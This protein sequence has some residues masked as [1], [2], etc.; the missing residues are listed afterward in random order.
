MSTPFFRPNHFTLPQAGTTELLDV[1]D[2]RLTSVMYRIVDGV[3]TL[4]ASHT[5]S[6]GAGGT[7]LRWYE[8]RQPETTPSLYQQGIYQPDSIHRWNSSIAVDG[9]KHRR[10][11][12][13]LHLLDVSGH[14]LQPP[15]GPA[16]CTDR[17]TRGGR[18]L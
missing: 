9:E 8:V 18:F 2:G 3:G 7:E 16:T 15:P 6:N 12:Q 13:R 10:G 5:V 11:L 4:W 14:P 17:S 1:Y